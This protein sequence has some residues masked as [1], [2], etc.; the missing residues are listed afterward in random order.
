MNSDGFHTLLNH[1][2]ATVLDLYQYF[3]LLG[4]LTSE[5]NINVPSFLHPLFLLLGLILTLI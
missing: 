3:R 5:K 1:Y 2:G 4:S